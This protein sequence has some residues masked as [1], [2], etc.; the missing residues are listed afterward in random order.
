MVKTLNRPG[1]KIIYKV[2]EKNRANP[3]KRLGIVFGILAAITGILWYGIFDYH[4]RR[5]DVILYSWNNL[6]LQIAK[7]AARSAEAWLQVRIREQ[8]LDRAKT[9][10]EI[11]QRFIKPILLLDSG[12][13]WIYN[14]NYVIY[15]EN[16]NFPE[17]Y[18]GK[19]MREIFDLQKENGAYH[20]EELCQG[21]LAGRQGMGWYVW[22]PD[23]GR[24]FVAWAPVRLGNEV[25]TV[26]LST[27]EA[28]IYDH[29]GIPV[30]FRREI[31][32]GI[33]VTALICGVFF[34]VWQQQR[35]DHEI[36]RLME[37][38]SLELEKANE[39]L[40][41][42][43]GERERAEK[44][45]ERLMGELEAKYK[46]ERD[47]WKEISFRAAHKV[48]NAIFGLRGEID[49]LQT[50]FNKKPLNE[51]ELES[52]IRE[53]KAGLREAN[54]I[55]RE[56]KKYYRPDQLRLETG[57]I[58][59][60]VEHAIAQVGKAVGEKVSLIADLSEHLNP[61]E[62]DRT[63]L[64]QCITELVENACHFMYYKGRITIRTAVASEVEKRLMGMRG[65]ALALSVRDSGIGVPKDNK[66]LLFHPFFSTS[67]KGSGMGLAIV[68]QYV[69]LH[70]GKI[71][72]IGVYGGGAE[73]LILLPYIDTRKSLEKEETT[74]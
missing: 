15:D 46:E 48:G 13:A 14:R 36:M 69:E 20:Y 57:H 18:K 39:E 66:T 37:Q 11:F 60:V 19:N 59:R 65:D 41:Y 3:M 34:L 26:G 72:E 27:P 47:A 70:G 67:A 55:V 21:V 1:W 30:Q 38:K 51:D 73:F 32:A 49:W 6:Q 12:A 44:E 42:Q 71:S 2:A 8:G 35:R 22:R 29:F 24:E 43:L 68:Q 61:I 16:S 17:I 58:N 10:Q 28:E 23:K 4:G 64:R 9:E 56:F 62:M 45:R 31:T 74:A 63:K 33:L 40:T 53:A 7:S 54:S 25:W 5:Q 52:A 50:V